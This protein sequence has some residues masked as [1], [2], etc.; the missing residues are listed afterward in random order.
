MNYFARI[1]DRFAIKLISYGILLHASLCIAAI[2][3]VIAAP[4]VV[5]DFVTDIQLTKKLTAEAQV[6]SA[7]LVNRKEERWDSQTGKHLCYLELPDTEQRFNDVV[8]RQAT[9]YLRSNPAGGLDSLQ[10][11]SHPALNDH[12]APLPRIIE[13]PADRSW[14]S[15]FHAVGGR[16]LESAILILALQFAL[17]AAAIYIAIRGYHL[18]KNGPGRNHR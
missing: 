10:I 13:V 5:W 7:P 8:I 2:S 6:I 18:I 9:P 17:G 14:K 11:Y 1:G 16:S 12:A 3:M 15:V 4:F